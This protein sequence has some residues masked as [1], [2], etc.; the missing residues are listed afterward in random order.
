MRTCILTLPHV[1]L[2]LSN[3]LKSSLQIE[4]DSYFSVVAGSNLITRTCTKAAL[5]AA[6]KK[7][8]YT[9]FIELNQYLMLLVGRG[10][11]PKR[12]HGLDLRAI[13]GSTLQLPDTPD[14]IDVFGREYPE[15]RMPY[16]MARIS[17]LFDPLNRLIHDAVIAPYHDDERSLLLQHIIAMKPG[18]L[19]LLDAGY[20][21]FWL[22]ATLT[23]RKIE[24]C[25][26]ASLRS[27]AVICDFVAKGRPQ[28]IVTLTAHPA[29]RQECIDRGLPTTPIKVRLVRVVLQDGS[30]EVLITSL[31]DCDTYPYEEFQE[32]YHLRWSQE[33]SYKFLKC[34]VEL[35]NWSGKSALSVYQDYHAKILAANLTMALVMTAQDEVDLKHVNDERPKQ[36]N[37][38]YALSAMKD[39]LVRML[40]TANPLEIIRSLV[41]LFV[42]TIEVV[43][44][45]RAFIRRKDIKPARHYAAYKHGR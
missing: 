41:S 32:L 14:I 35:A 16:T 22:F 30:I 8:K 20:P 39:A 7:L 42:R 27:W 17:H 43:R 15:D 13:D 33:E 37:K 44:V 18:E 45:G 5:S 3:M 23:V 34:R 40:A 28:A 21:A 6:R 31:L 26:R 10:F 24:W 1:V 19:L 25:A 12:W 9:A 29:A 2:I 11:T 36:V 4:V 38:T